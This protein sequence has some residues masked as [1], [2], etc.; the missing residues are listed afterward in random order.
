MRQ[1]AQPLPQCAVVIPSRT[2]ANDRPICPDQLTRPPLVNINQS[3][4]M[5][6]RFTLCGERYHFSDSRSF[7]PALSSI[8]QKPLEL[9]VLGLSDRNRLVSDT[10]NPPY[11]AFQ[12]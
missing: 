11:L 8:S 12:L 2:V 10:S 1:L 3:L 9:P 7:R 4:K 5:H 6:D